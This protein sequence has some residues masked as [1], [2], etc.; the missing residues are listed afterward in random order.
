MVR[1]IHRSVLVSGAVLVV[2]IA[3]LRSQALKVLAHGERGSLKSG[4]IIAYGDTPSLR[5]R[6]LT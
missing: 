6:V 5:A 1:Y 4:G 2:V 3:G